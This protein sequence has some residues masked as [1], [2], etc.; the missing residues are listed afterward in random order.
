LDS[1]SHIAVFAVGKA[2]SSMCVAA[3][4]KLSSNLSTSTTPVSSFV[5]SKPSHVTDAENRY[6]KGCG[7]QISYG[8]HPVPDDDSTSASLELME[9]CQS[10]PRSTLFLALVSGGTSGEQR[11]KRCQTQGR[12]MF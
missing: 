12:V 11:K 10:R 7:T 8:S 2:S 4:K 1:Y 6:L 5:L 9:Y 3:L